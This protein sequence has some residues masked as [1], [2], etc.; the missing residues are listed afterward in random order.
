MN[1]QIV[2]LCIIQFVIIQCIGNSIYYKF[3]INK[4]SWLLSYKDLCTYIW[5]FLT[6]I[7]LI[8][9]LHNQI[10]RQSDTK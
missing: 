5:T 2:N 3:I 9:E 8:A 10:V 6:G 1:I 7:F 4:L